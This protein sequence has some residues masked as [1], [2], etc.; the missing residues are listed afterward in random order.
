[1]LLV[2]SA[3][4]AGC[5]GSPKDDDGAAADDGVQFQSDVLQLSLPTMPR[6]PPALGERT[7]DKAPEWRLGEWWKY[8]LTDGFAGRTY[9]FTRVVAGTDRAAGNY[10]V[11][12]PVDEFNNDIMLF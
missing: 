7:L 11:G 3:F 6:D 1:S 2:A 4:L 10:L 5:S 8:R 12:F 9:E